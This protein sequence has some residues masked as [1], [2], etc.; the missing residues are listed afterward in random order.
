MIEGKLSREAGPAPAPGTDYSLLSNVGLFRGVLPDE[1]NAIEHACR[2]RRFSAQEIIIDRDS[3]TNDVF[4]VVRGRIRIVNYSVAGREVAFDDLGDGSYFGELAAIDNEPRSA[5]VIALTDTLIVALP[6]KTFLDAALAYPQ[7]GLR[8]MQRMARV[9]RSANERIMDLSTLGANS[10]VHAELL[11]QARSHGVDGN[12]AVI[13]PIPVHS[14]IASRASTTRETVA[15]VLNDLARQGI[16]KRTRD[17]LV[18]RDLSRLD[19]LVQDV[20][21]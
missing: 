21:G 17:G 13:D 3:P 16:L 6:A 20:R 4:F 8:V 7:I 11:R 14:D 5:S 19:A 1:L 2:Y 18:I 12:H 10:R 9:I 15:R